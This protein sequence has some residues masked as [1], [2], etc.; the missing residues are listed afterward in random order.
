MDKQ[1]SQ[2]ELFDQFHHMILVYKNQKN[3]FFLGHCY[4]NNGRDTAK[5]LL[6]LYKDALPNMDFLS[7]WNYL[8][9]HS[10]AIVVVEI[11]EAKLGIMDFL[12][13]YKPNAG[14]EE[15]ECVEINSFQEIQQNLEGFKQNI[16]KCFLM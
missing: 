11:K 15:I 9:D 2:L 12:S 7:A 4:Q 14:I 16:V 6:F 10:Y 13:C 8:D 3:E 1:N 5:Y